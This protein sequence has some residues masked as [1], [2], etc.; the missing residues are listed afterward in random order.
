MSDLDQLRE[1][2]RVLTI[3]LNQRLAN[4]EEIGDEMLQRIEELQAAALQN[5]MNQARFISEHEHM[6][7]QLEETVRQL[8]TAVS[9]LTPQKPA[10]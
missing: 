6:L 8:K 7:E 1:G 9:H 3:A 4:V 10:E 5:Q 2:L